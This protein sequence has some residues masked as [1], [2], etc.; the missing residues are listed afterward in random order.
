MTSNASRCVIDPKLG[1]QAICFS[2]CLSSGIKK[3]LSKTSIYCASI[4]ITIVIYIGF[5]KIK[6]S[7]IHNYFN[8][9]S[10]IDKMLVPYQNESDRV[11]I[12]SEAKSEGLGII[13]LGCKIKINQQDVSENEYEECLKKSCYTKT[14]VKGLKSFSCGCIPI[15]QKY[16]RSFYLSYSLG[17][18]KFL[19][20]PRDDVSKKDL[21]KIYN[22]TNLYVGEQ[23]YQCS[24]KVVKCVFK[25]MAGLIVFII[26]NT[27]IIILT[28]ISI[29]ESISALSTVHHTSGDVF[30]S[31]IN[32]SARTAKIILYGILFT[33]SY[34]ITPLLI[35]FIILFMC[36]KAKTL[37]YII[38]I[39]YS[40]VVVIIVVVVLI[41]MTLISRIN[42]ISSDTIVGWIITNIKKCFNEIDH[43]FVDNAIK[44]I[45][46]KSKNSYISIMFIFLLIL[47]LVTVFVDDITY[48]M[49]SMSAIFFI[50]CAL[51]F[52][53]SHQFTEPYVHGVYNN[54][55]Q[56]KENPY[57]NGGDSIALINSKFMKT[58]AFN[59]TSAYLRMNFCCLPNSEKVDHNKIP[60]PDI[61]NPL[62]KFN[63]NLNSLEDCK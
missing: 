27:W 12:F 13:N 22:I 33:F 55:K 41:F 36:K 59:L 32:I 31:Y 15:S 49:I 48:S 56:D 26:I 39:S 38:S 9:Y 23:A 7:D 34:W 62:N 20:I 10:Y 42:N 57:I 47:C 51:S 35:W 37:E 52:Y 19:D 54:I 61:G 2:P 1:Q 11:P 18:L 29:I 17:L 6:F 24:Q 53:F 45:S 5:V 25:V 60:P 63:K 28:L 14:Q 43:S 46:I 44:D 58:P 3:F 21:E 8:S 30:F 16:I 4:F 40:I 50:I